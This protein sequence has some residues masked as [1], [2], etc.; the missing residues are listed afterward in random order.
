MKHKQPITTKPGHRGGELVV[1]LPPAWNFRLRRVLRSLL[2]E[3]LPDPRPN[4]RYGL[5]KL[6]GEQVVEYEVRTNGL[7]AVTLRPFMI[8]DELEELGDL[9]AVATVDLETADQRVVGANVW[10]PVWIQ[11]EGFRRIVDE[12][13]FLEME[14]GPRGYQPLVGYTVL[15]KSGAA[16]D[17]VSHQLIAHR[18]YDLKSAAVA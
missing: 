18:S 7:R 10:G 6:L 15:E 9:E 8:Y 13:I 11:I 3:T 16:V 1:Q 4:N 12:V 2:E 5:S 17:M 14:E